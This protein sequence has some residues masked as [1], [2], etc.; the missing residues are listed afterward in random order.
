[1]H[2]WHWPLKQTWQKAALDHGTGTAGTP[3]SIEVREVGGEDCAGEVV[4]F[5]EGGSCPDW[6]QR[7]L[8][9]SAWSCLVA[10]NFCRE[11]FCFL[12]LL[13]FSLYNEFGVDGREYG[14]W[15]RET[16]FRFLQYNIEY[17]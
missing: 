14:Y 1:M 3:G 10:R 7:S 15:S 17:M 5:G 11:V 2:L 13:L 16:R 6:L 12:F 4:G 9:M 8:E